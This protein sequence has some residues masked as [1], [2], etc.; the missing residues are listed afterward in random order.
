MYS[1]IGNGI[2]ISGPVLGS[3]A[4][5]VAWLNAMMPDLARDTSTTLRDRFTD[6]DGRDARLRGSSRARVDLGNYNVVDG[7]GMTKIFVATAAAEMGESDLAHALVRSMHDRY[8]V[9]ER[10][11]ARRF[12]GVSTVTNAHHTLTR[13][14]RPDGLRDLIRGTVPPE[15]RTGPILGIAPHTDGL[16]AKAVTDGSALELALRP[17]HGSRR[18]RLGLRRLISRRTYRVTGAIAPAVSPTSPARAPSKSTSRS[19]STRIADRKIRSH[20]RSSSSRLARA[21]QRVP[22]WA[23]GPTGCPRDRLRCKRFRQQPHCHEPRRSRHQRTMN[24]HTKSPSAAARDYVSACATLTSLIDLAAHP[25]TSPRLRVALAEYCRRHG[26]AD[27]GLAA[28]L[29]FWKQRRASLTPADYEAIR[30]VLSRDG[31]ILY[32]F[33][34]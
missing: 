12:A 16:V 9:D 24:Q 32:A 15:W 17:G 18:V 29:S 14:N 20:A 23:R 28:S 33:H 27:P 19:R 6:F 4:G 25:A 7:D 26:T 3:D 8:R 34:D 10:N 30:A 31:A 22:T 1:G 21:P 13:F 11:G 5:V 2:A